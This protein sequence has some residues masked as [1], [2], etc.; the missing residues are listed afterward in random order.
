[1]EVEEDVVEEGSS[2]AVAEEDFVAAGS[3]AEAEA[4]AFAEA[5][6]LLVVATLMAELAFS[7]NSKKVVR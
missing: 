3:V 1:M 6:E 7:N 5:A 4:A 2:A